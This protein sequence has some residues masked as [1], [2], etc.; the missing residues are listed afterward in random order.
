ML[1]SSMRLAN[2]AMAITA[3]G[4]VAAGTIVAARGKGTVGGGFPARG[5]RSGD[6]SCLHEREETLAIC[7]HLNA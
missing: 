1:H 7:V 5:N 6:G 2:T 3:T 4:C